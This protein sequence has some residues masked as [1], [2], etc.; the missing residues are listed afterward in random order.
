MNTQDPAWLERMYNNRTL[1]PDHAANLALWA[2]ESA[3]TRAVLPMHA[4][5]RYG[6]GHAETLDIFPAP[7]PDAPALVFIHGGYWRALDKSDHSFIA[8]AFNDRG[9][10]V[11]VPNYALCP[12]T[13]DRPVAIPDIVM[14]MVRALAWTYR[15]VAEHGGDPSRITVAG[16][17]VGGHMAAMMLGCDWQ[18]VAPDLPVR[19]VR[20]ALSISGLHDLRPLQRVPF[21]AGTIHLDDAEARRLSPALWPAPPRGQLYAVAG[22][23]ESAEFA[24]Q[25]ALIQEAWGRNVV[26]V[27]ELLPGHNHFSIVEALADPS[28][29]LHRL[30]VQLLE[31]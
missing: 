10:C 11:V 7:V 24:R 2:A 29:R 19:L 13:A 8:R 31:S 3:A 14:Q 22:A 15:H 27:C 21:L 9:I 5:L 25:N 23:D 18:S 28:N 26:P 16:H 4:D 17:S 30:A 20:N 12:G 1:V 6:D